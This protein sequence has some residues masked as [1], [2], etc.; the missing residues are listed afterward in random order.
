MLLS[1]G[2]Q[3]RGRLQP[4]QAALEAKRL[5]VPVYTV[6][7][8]TP[9]GKIKINDGTFSTVIPAER[10]SSV[11]VLCHILARIPSSDEEG[12]FSACEFDLKALK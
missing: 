11:L 6:A 7:L 4:I 12:I 2:A 3:N 9:N 5:K 1:D 10:S 8:G